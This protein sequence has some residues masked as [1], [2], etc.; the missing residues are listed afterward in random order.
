L[1]FSEPLP[2]PGLGIGGTAM[3]MALQAARVLPDTVV[4]VQA[5]GTGLAYWADVLTTIATVILSLGI[6]IGGIM[7]I[8]TLFI[9]RKVLLKLNTIL[10]QVKTDVAPL[11]KHGHAAAENVNFITTSVRMDFEQLSRTVQMANQQLVHTAKLAEERINEFNA[12]MKVV[13]EEAE[14]LFINTASTIRGV[15]A[16]TETL[17]RLRA[18]DDP[19]DA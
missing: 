13:Q 6:V 2:V 10:G 15:Q 17:R 1:S 11:V 8:P 19:H 4:T 12:L 7:I 9:L 14:D 5:T 18:E 16:G 3:M